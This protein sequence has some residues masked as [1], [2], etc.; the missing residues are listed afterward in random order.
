[1]LTFGMSTLD[2]SQI[3][4]NS[5]FNIYDFYN[6]SYLY[7]F[8][9]R[10]CN[11]HCTRSRTSL[12]YCCS[13]PLYDNHAELW[14][15]HRHQN[16]QLRFHQNRYYRCNH[17]THPGY[18]I[19]H[20][21]DSCEL[22]LGC[23]VTKFHNI[24]KSLMENTIMSSFR[25]KIK[26]RCTKCLSQILFQN[27]RFAGRTLISCIFEILINPHRFYQYRVVVTNNRSFLGF[28]VNKK[29]FEYR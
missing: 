15:I 16:K 9:H 28:F 18:Y 24:F 29:S 23:T 19:Q 21:H 10:R 7:M 20:L 27:S 17:K 25:R 1:M 22:D 26:I 3:W 4:R 8:S 14:Y 2:I 12:V 11:Q 13:W 6:I 5:I